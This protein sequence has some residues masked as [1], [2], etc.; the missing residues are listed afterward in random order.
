MLCLCYLKI[1]PRLI[2][3][4]NLC[5]LDKVFLELCREAHVLSIPKLSICNG[6]GDIRPIRTMIFFSLSAKKKNTAI[7]LTDFSKA[8]Y[9]FNFFF[10]YL[11]GKKQRVKTS[12]KLSTTTYVDEFL[13]MILKYFFTH[14]LVTA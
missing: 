3:I 4:S 2:H 14:R 7:N 8:F 9:P 6:L 5:L 13:I 11:R 1:L 10:N 12:R